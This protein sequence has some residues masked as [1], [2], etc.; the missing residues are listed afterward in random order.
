MLNHIR[1]KSEVS[2]D[3][4]LVNTVPN[5]DTEGSVDSNDHA[6]EKS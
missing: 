5:L 4:A 2:N 1:E 3:V 6:G